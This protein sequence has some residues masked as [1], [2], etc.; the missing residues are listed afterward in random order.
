[1]KIVVRVQLHG[2]NKA[3]LAVY[4]EVYAPRVHVGRPPQLG[5]GPREKLHAFF[6]QVESQ[7]LL[8]LIVTP[9]MEYPLIKKYN[10]KNNG[11]TV[12]LV[13]YMGDYREYKVQL[14]WKYERVGFIKA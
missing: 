10:L 4:H 1:M 11:P 13:L 6:M 2:P 12:K 7:G 3:F 9:V 8:A 14:Q 5:H